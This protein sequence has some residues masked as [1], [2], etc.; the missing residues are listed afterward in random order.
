MYIC[1]IEVSVNLDK[2]KLHDSLMAIIVV[3]VMLRTLQSCLA[4]ELTNYYQ[5]LD[6]TL[7]GS[8]NNSIYYVIK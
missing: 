7:F 4:V 3:N 8:I 2:S 1:I 6:Y 5:S